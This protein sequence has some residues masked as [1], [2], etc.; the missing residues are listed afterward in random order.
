M[1]SKC[2]PP[3]PPHDSC[4]LGLGMMPL[5]TRNRVRA[6]QI[7]AACQPD[8]IFPIG[9]STPNT[10]GALSCFHFRE[11]LVV[12]HTANI[13][14]LCHDF[15]VT[16]AYAILNDLPSFLQYSKH[17]FHCF[18]KDKKKVCINVNAKLGSRVK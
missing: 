5:V 11:H 17:T 14:Y 1:I 9:T 16:E 18:I 4:L 6:V 3:L 12:S 8:C 15:D 10:M 2:S 7:I 13:E